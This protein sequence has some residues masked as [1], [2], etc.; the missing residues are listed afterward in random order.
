ML[1]KTP[2]SENKITTPKNPTVGYMLALATAVCFTINSVGIRYV[3]KTNTD[4]TVSSGIFWGFIGA[5]LF[6]SP[7]YILS[8]KARKRLITTFRRDGKVVFAIAILTSTGAVLWIWA[9]KYAIVGAVSLLAKTL[10]IHSAILGFI[11]LKE[12]FTLIEG[13]GFIAVIPGVILISTLTTEVDPRAVW[14]ILI[15][16]FIYAIQSLLV[17]KFAPNLHGMEFTFLRASFMVMIFGSAFYSFGL[18]QKIPIM[19]VALL[20][21]VSVSGLMFGRAFYFEAH[22]YLDISK[23]NTTMLIEP[24]FV[25]IIAYFF[26]SESLSLTKISGTLFILGGLYL[27]IH[28]NLR[29]K[30]SKNLQ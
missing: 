11:F 15:S 4:L 17:K 21:I 20:G 9:L 26:L 24:V 2:P 22:K 25:L 16:A 27:I 7:Y 13:I 19:T 5:I 14:A 1:K 8:Q 6:F 18:I 30:T 28:K 10:V 3:F 29:R 23:L 12:R